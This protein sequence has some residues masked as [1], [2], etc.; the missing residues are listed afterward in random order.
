MAKCDLFEELIKL[1]IE[2][3]IFIFYFMKSKEKEEILKL[4]DM[5]REREDNIKTVEHMIELEKKFGVE[6]KPIKEVL[7]KTEL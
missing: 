4:A 3:D 2:R 6:F 1:K 7:K 5:I